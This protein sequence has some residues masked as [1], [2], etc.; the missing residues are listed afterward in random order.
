M[1]SS[2]CSEAAC[3]VA[4]DNGDWWQPTEAE[5]MPN[6]KM[7]R[8]RQRERE[9]ETNEATTH[10]NAIINGKQATENGNGKR[11]P[12]PNLSTMAQSKARG[13]SGQWVWG[14]GAG[15]MMEDTLN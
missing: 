11:Q 1:K 3:A 14:V 6:K 5:V 7:T 9:K 15:Q 8:Q 12:N 13:G 4:D 10:N 2:R